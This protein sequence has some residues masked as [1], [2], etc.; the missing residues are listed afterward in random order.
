LRNAER[1]HT[2]HH[3]ATRVP[4]ETAHAAVLRTRCA[5]ARFGSTSLSFNRRRLRRHQLTTVGT[6]LFG[7]VELR[8]SGGRVRPLERGGA[9]VLYLAWLESALGLGDG[10][11]VRARVRARAR[12]IGLGVG[13][14]LGEACVPRAARPFARPL[15]PPVVIRT[16][17][18]WLAHTDA[19]SGFAAYDAPCAEAHRHMLGLGLARF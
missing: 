18:A 7:R 11:R 3:Y 9:G 14:G 8:G 13:L 1:S 2:H 16:L 17:S 10:V 4:R 19:T 15:P 12:V 6:M 5:H